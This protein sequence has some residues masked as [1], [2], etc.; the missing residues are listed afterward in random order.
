MVK[1]IDL[2]S[3]TR[4]LGASCAEFLLQHAEVFGESKDLYL[5]R[6]LSITVTLGT[7]LSGC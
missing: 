5:Q 7:M 4:D 3:I 6:N 2:Y 1:T